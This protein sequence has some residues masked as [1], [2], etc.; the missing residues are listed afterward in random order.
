MIISPESPL[1]RLPQRLDREAVLFLD[2]IRLAIEMAEASLDRL[3][4]ALAELSRDDTPPELVQS[5]VVSALLDAWAI[6][7]STHRL[8]EL[9]QHMPGGK[10]K[11][12][13]LQVFYR[14]T[15]SAET[16]RHFIQHLREKVSPVAKGAVPL[17]GIL[18][19]RTTTDPKTGRERGYSIISGSFYPGVWAR[20][21]QFGDPVQST[22]GFVHLNAGGTIV[23]LP[24]LVDRMKPLAP[25][26]EAAV[27]RLSINQALNASDQVMVFELTPVR[28]E[29]E[30]DSPPVEPPASV[31]PTNDVE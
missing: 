17:W 29:D 6:I 15:T 27:A 26:F 30:P 4:S 16:L 24:A 25:L 3:G 9:L 8:R 31:P 5:L 20:G 14:N 2:G 23:D 13:E 1:R 19:W 21:A 7:D 22:F 28:R 18:S 11:R 12:P 10:Q